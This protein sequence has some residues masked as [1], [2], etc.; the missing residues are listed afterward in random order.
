ML[1][2]LSVMLITLDKRIHFEWKRMLIKA[3]TALINL[4]V[5]SDYRRQ[6]EFDIHEGRIA[7]R[8]YVVLVIIAMIILIFYTIESKQ[9]FIITV[10]SPTQEQYAEVRERYRNT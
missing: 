10:E 1:R 8:V 4:N 3:K 9:S 2:L 7:T 6:D 5:F